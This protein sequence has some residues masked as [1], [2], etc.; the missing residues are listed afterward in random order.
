MATAV[1]VGAP[2]SATGAVRAADLG[3]ALPTTAVAVPNVAFAAL[4]YIGEDGLSQTTERSVEKIRAWGGDVVRT[5][6]TEH[7]VTYQLAFLETSA[8]VLAEVYGAE[9]VTTTAATTL[10]G[11]LNT[12]K[13]KS[14]TLPRKSYIFDMKDGNALVRVVVPNGQ[15]VEVGD[16]Q[17]VHTN[18]VQYS[19]TIE[20][21]P[22]ATDVKAYIYTVGDDKLPV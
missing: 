19:V 6:Q 13:V 20:A 10:S 16:V 22:D 15:I 14:G 17:Y 12:V 4:G 1:I 7:G 18:A 3:T 21:Y 11:S 9:N 8:L 5:V 2:A